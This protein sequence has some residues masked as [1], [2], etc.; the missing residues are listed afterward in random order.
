MRKIVDVVYDSA[1]VGDRQVNFK[2]TAPFNYIQST[3]PVVIS[4]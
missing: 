3:Y 1:R 2:I 4:M